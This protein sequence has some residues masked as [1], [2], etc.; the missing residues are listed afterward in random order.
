M[1]HSA[2]IIHGSD[3]TAAGATVGICFQAVVANHR[4][5]DGKLYQE[6]VK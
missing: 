3:C 5:H 1:Q 6:R 4:V 2:Y